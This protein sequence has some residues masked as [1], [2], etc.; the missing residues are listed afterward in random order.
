MAI[1]TAAQRAQLDK[2]G[3]FILE[4]YFTAEEMD[5]LAAV[6][7]KYTEA[8]NARLREKG[9]EGI[10]RADEIQFTAFLAEHDDAIRAFATQ[11]K[12][13]L[14]AAELLGP[15][16]RLYWNQSVYKHPETPRDFPWHQDNGYTPIDPEQY[17]TCW[18]A[19]SDATLENGCIW[20]L[21]G[22][23]K[24]GTR[25][26][27]DSPI[28]KVGYDGPDPGVPVPLRKGSMAVFSSLLLHKSG[29]NRTASEV[30]KAYIMQYCHAHTR[31][32]STGATVEDR[33]LVAHNGVKV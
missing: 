22:S 14:L 18:L 4:D 9:T 3:F 30:R 32:R 12:M 33:I 8:H 10:S 16:V 19:L 6:I 23:H 11:E 24:N 15:D 7:E 26:H 2:D 1:V 28:G 20:V 21:P 25:P 27:K 17:L 31:L 13:A 5:Q 29:P